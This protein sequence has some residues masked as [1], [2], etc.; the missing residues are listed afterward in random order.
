MARKL[1]DERGLIH[2]IANIKKYISDFVGA[3]TL[4]FMVNDA[5]VG[6]FSA[7][8]KNDKIIDLTI[9][10][11]DEIVLENKIKKIL[12]ENPSGGISDEQLQQALSQL[13][14]AGS[15]TPGGPATS[16]SKLEHSFQFGDLYFDG[17][18]DVIIPSYNG[19]IRE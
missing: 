6:S 14:Y 13:N 11:I 10:S 1:L 18:E 5:E 12:A 17:S 16:A 4:T 19:G 7:N 3:G 8:E 9:S 15:N 2:L